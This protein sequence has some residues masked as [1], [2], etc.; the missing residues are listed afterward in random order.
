MKITLVMSCKFK[1]T[2][3]QC[4]G[5]KM[6]SCIQFWLLI[7]RKK[8]DSNVT[9]GV[10]YGVDAF[11]RWSNFICTPEAGF[12]RI[13]RAPKI[14]ASSR[15][16]APWACMN[17]LANT[18]LHQGQVPRFQHGWLKISNSLGYPHYD[19][20]EGCTGN[21]VLGMSPIRVLFQP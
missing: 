21:Q 10:I 13:K 4:Q 3:C 6:Q 1:L 15:R 20:V 2:R 5:I 11:S 19:W 18:Y 12:T 14:I 7:E 16:R 8:D 9:T 17:K